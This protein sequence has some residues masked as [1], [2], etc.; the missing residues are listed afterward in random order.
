MWERLSS[1]RRRVMKALG[2]GAALSAVGGRVRASDDDD[3]NGGSDRGKTVH[4][5]QT[6]IAPPTNQQRPADFFY[7]PTGLHIRPGDVVKFVF[8]TPDH[9]VV[10]MHPAFGMR[11]RVPLGVDAF[12]SPLK[13]W[14]PESIPGDQIEPPAEPGGE[15]GEDGEGGEGG[16]DG[17]GG[18]GGDGSDG[19]D[20]E[21]DD[22][23][24]VPD[25]W[26]H[27]FETPGV[28]D[29]VCSPHETF[30]MAM[31]VVVGDV[32]EARF[33][34]SDPEQL[35]GPRA[36]P[37]GLSRVTLTDPALEPAAIVENER[38]LWSD[39]VAN[40]GGS[41]NGGGEGGNGGDGDS[42]NGGDDEG[43]NGG[44]DEGGNGGDGEGGNG[45]DGDSGNGG[46]G[47]SGNGGDGD[48][49]GSYSWEW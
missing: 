40:G 18:N 14:R 19:D 25:V 44:D 15:N 43:G 48:D 20:G 47:D 39:L 34:T 38:V 7:Q 30:G 36:G 8:T 13:G 23:M 11:R 16:E 26:L 42:G 41:E 45:G 32:T 28:Y 1:D 24:P 4:E 9:N 2:G 33:N 5:V 27:L 29:L 17:E 37:V 22:S 10:S 12:S 21:A 35:P 6:L 31:R 3:E 49:S 46:D